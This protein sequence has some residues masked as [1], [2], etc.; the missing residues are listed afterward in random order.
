MT[1]DVETPGR[2]SGPGVERA[3]QQ[4]PANRSE[5]SGRAQRLPAYGRLL[6]DALAAGYRPRRCGGGI[7]VTSDWGYARA[8]APARLVVP[9]D[10]SPDDLDFTFLRGCEVAVIVPPRDEVHGELLLAAI[11][12][13]GAKLAYLGINWE[14]ES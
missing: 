13:A 7:I 3:Q 9:R 12:D 10:D 8:A 5:M 14:D 6:R 1:A 11:L 4:G 2:C